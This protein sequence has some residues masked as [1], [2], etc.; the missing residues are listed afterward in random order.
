[1]EGLDF[2]G[3]VKM[4]TYKIEKSLHKMKFFEDMKLENP[5]EDEEDDYEDY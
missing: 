3:G 2:F 1:M 4:T 5:D